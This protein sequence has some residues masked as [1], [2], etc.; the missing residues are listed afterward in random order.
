MTI[1]TDDELRFLARH[2]FTVDDVYDGRGESQETRRQGAKAA[3]KTLILGPRCRAE[4]HRLRTRSHHCVQC[5]PK[6]LAFQQRYN[7]PGYVYIA[8]S[9]FGR[10]I[11]IG[12]AIDI[13]QRESQLRSERHAGFGDWEVLFFIKVS[14][15]GRVEYEASSRVKGR[16]LFG[17]YFKDNISQTATEVIRCSFSAAH[18]AIVE[19]V[20]NIS[21]YQTWQ[22]TRAGEY[23]F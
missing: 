12:T 10:V 5:D 1:F 3:G 22:W 2:G 4:G 13:T 7:S 23:E 9:L 16:R 14:Q 21:R 6:K 15:A 20:G 17:T 11:K 18:A 19:T 8:G